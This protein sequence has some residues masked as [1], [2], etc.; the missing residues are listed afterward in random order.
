MKVVLVSPSSKL[1]LGIV[2]VAL[3]VVLTPRV[4]LLKPSDLN[5]SVFSLL[6]TMVPRSALLGKVK[7]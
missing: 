4:A 1:L 2:L 7:N 5:N 6:K 3:R